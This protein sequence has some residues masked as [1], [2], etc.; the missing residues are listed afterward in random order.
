ML[1]FVMLDA[2]M[3]DAVYGGILWCL[4]VSIINAVI[5]GLIF[6]R[7]FRFNF[8]EPLIV[9][10]RMLLPHGLEQVIVS[11]FLVAP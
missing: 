7:C 3:L 6:A 2:V 1:D 11:Q 10:F 9:Y 5:L 8:F 4:I